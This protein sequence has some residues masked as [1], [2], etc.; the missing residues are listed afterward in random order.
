MT[1]HTAGV[2]QL[3][4]RLHE[5]EG[6]IKRAEANAGALEQMLGLITARGFP[7]ATGTTPTAFSGQIVGECDGTTGVPGTVTVTS[8]TVPSETATATVGSSGNYSG[9]INLS[10][11]TV[12]K[13][14]FTP[15]LSRWQSITGESVTEGMSVG[16]PRVF[17]T[18]T[19]TVA[20]GYACFSPCM[21]APIKT[22]LDFNS[23]NFGAF[24][25]TR[26][27][28]AGSWVGTI[29]RDIAAHGACA[30]QTHVQISYDLSSSGSFSVTYT[31]FVGGCP[32]TQPGGATAPNAAH[33]LSSSSC[34]PTFSRVY[35][36]TSQ[37]FAA[38]ET[39]TVTEP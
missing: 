13:V 21:Q 14:E 34:A 15:T 24:T 30:A 11:N 9:T 18:I 35:T 28:G 19:A 3:V 7:Q 2:R 26:A 31:A 25:V 8:L 29:F 17:G 12:V 23:T 37:L 4:A 5:F 22:T 16:V 33:T 6:R 1:E 10:V 20:A 27:S 36:S 32:H 38:A 39:L